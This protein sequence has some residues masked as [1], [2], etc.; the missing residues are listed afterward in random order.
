MIKNKEFWFIVGSQFLYGSEVLD[1]V[2]RRAAEMVEYMNASGLL[3]YKLVYRA[4]VKTEAEITQTMKEA[5]Y[6]DDCFG[7]VTWCHT[8]SPSKMWIHGFNLLQK[9]YCHLATQYNR[10]IPN[11]EI[12]MDFI[13]L[14]QA[15][16][17]DREHGFIAARMHL[18]RKVIA[19]YWQDESVL[20]E[21]AAWMRACVGYA[22]S[23]TLR[24]VRFGDNMRDVAVTE[25]DKVESE[26]KL[27]WQVDYWPVGHLVETMDAVTDAEVDAKMEEYHAR[28]DFATND[29]DT[30]RY[31]ARE[32][33]A[34]RR[35]LD[36]EGA[37][38]FI[39]TFQD[40]YGM[41]QLPGLASQNMMADGY[42]YGG[43]GDWKVSAM[44]AIMKAMAQGLEGGTLFMEDYTYDLTPGREVSLGAHML[45]VCPS[46]A[47]QR[48]R[49][50]VHDLGIGDR[51]PPA[52]LVFEGKAGPGIVVSLIDMGGRMRLIIQDIEVIK[53]TLDMPNLPV[54]RVMWKPAPNLL[55]GVKCWIHAGGAHHTVLSTAVTAEIMRDWAEMMQIECVRITAETTVE[56]FKKELLYNDIAWKLKKF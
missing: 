20:G 28:Y 19:G 30:V 21:L 53:P 27:G 50:E 40:L 32:E 31:Q 52:R 10:S 51:R 55:A 38:A 35:I 37:C 7:V 24:V 6:S 42:G 25:G 9:P 47:A 11:E 39:N 12:D 36:R 15:A 5:N 16:H 29:L 17:G 34:M 44:T 2:A 23:R 45:E 46:I 43:E 26:I 18:P 14:N 56:E 1:T 33:I 3:P 41:E 22:F 13:N 48:P 49:I 54:A 8:F 4:T